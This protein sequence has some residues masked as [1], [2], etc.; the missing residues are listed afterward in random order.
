MT[1]RYLFTT[2]TSPDEADRHSDVAVLPV[3]SFEQHGPH[4]PLITDTVI[5]CAIAEALASSYNLPLLAPVTFS[6]SHEHAAFPGTVSISPATLAAIVADVL[7][8]VVRAGIDHLVLVNA[9]G[10]NYVLNNVVQQANVTRRRALLFPGSA[11]WKAAR[12]AAGCV[13]ST[14][15]DMHAGEV[16]TSILLHVAPDLVGEGWAESDWQ[17]PDRP[18]LHLLGVQGYSPTGVIGSPSEASPEKGRR[19]LDALVDAFDQPLKL[20][21]SADSSSSGTSPTG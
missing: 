17:A 14:H 5:A 3:G 20:L 18:Y 19:L 8:D 6:C 1:G 13:T 15:D 7:A 2:A 16:E 11:D 4:L 12:S 21:R 10:G 9:H